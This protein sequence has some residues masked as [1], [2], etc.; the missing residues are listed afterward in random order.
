MSWRRCTRLSSP[1][2]HARKSATGRF[3]SVRPRTSTTA[4]SPSRTPRPFGTANGVGTS[5]YSCAPTRNGPRLEAGA[6]FI[7]RF[8]VDDLAAGPTRTQRRHS[9]LKDLSSLRLSTT[10]LHISQ[11][12]LVRRDLRRRRRI[13]RIHVRR[14]PTPRTIPR[15]RNLSIS[16]ERRTSHMTTRTK[17]RNIT[18]RSGITPLR[19]AHWTRTDTCTTNGVATSHYLYAP[20]KKGEMS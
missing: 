13:L 18:A 12:R 8:L 20:K 3:C 9:L 7:S 19:L 15:L 16:R 11:M 1:R 17:I 5:H 10:L 4:S 2:H 14:Q 6:R